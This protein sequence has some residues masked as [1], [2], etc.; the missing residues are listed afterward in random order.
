M[1][2]QLPSW[3]VVALGFGLGVVALLVLIRTDQSLALLKVPG[4]SA[5]QSIGDTKSLSLV[6]ETW[7]SA[8]PAHGC[9]R[10]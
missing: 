10:A 5:L 2:K 8:G 4:T 1:T 9:G 6:V 3:W 7:R